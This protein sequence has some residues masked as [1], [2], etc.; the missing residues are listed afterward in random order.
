MD[1]FVRIGI[2]HRRATARGPV[3]E[4]PGI[5]DNSSVI[6]G[7]GGIKINRVTLVDRRDI[8]GC[9][10]KR[11]PR[12]PP[13]R[14]G[15][16]QDV[17]GGAGCLPNNQ[18]GAKRTVT[19][20]RVKTH[21]ATCVVRTDHVEI[22]VVVKVVLAERRVVVGIQGTDI[23]SALERQVAVTRVKVGV[24]R[25]TVVDDQVGNARTVEVS[26]QHPIR[27]G[28][29]RNWRRRWRKATGAVATVEVNIAA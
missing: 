23:D 9:V 1:T 25:T 29:R 12:D 17:N 8:S 26:Q 14:C 4:I 3:T 10:G 22:T 2:R 20:A 6:V 15:N 19:V 24:S 7:A 13:R 18:R 27:I 21:S 16:R 5:V 11:L 28:P